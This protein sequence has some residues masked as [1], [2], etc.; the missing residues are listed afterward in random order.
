MNEKEFSDKLQLIEEKSFRFWFEQMKNAIQNGRM[1]DADISQVQMIRFF[2]GDQLQ[3]VLSQIEINQYYRNIIDFITEHEKDPYDDITYLKLSLCHLAIGDYIR[4]FKYLGIIEIKEDLPLE[5]YFALGVC[6]VRLNRFKTA[7][8]LFTKSQNSDDEIIKFDS[9][10]LKAFSLSKIER[11]N[12]SIILYQQLEDSLYSH[13]QISKEDIEFQI[14]HVLNQKNEIDLSCST[15]FSNSLT[16]A[17]SIYL[18]LEQ[19]NIDIVCVQRAYELILKGKYRDA[20]GELSNITTDCRS[21]FDRSLLM[22]YCFYDQRDFPNAS[23]CLFPLLSFDQIGWSIW[24]LVGLVLIRTGR[25]QSAI[26]A[27][28]N[29]RASN[30]LSTKILLNLAASYELEGRLNDAEKIYNDFPEADPL[31][32]YAKARLIYIR[33][34]SGKS[35][36][37]SVTPEI[38][39]IRIQDFFEP[40]SERAMKKFIDC[41]LFFSKET[42]DFLGCD[43]DF[44]EI[45]RNVTM[46]PNFEEFG[47]SEASEK[48]ENNPSI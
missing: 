46:F 5:Y 26:A 11:F 24:F 22:G 7:I 16:Q 35:Y 47:D 36:D 37:N 42:V 9:I 10:Y 19:K 8:D 12:E 2:R 14:A 15:Y 13:P 45:H 3:S 28:G 32:Q 4:A 41:P 31:N 48:S 25:I 27:F 43:P 44:S 40:P 17:N 18:N 20:F 39:E 6:N 30:L 33:S 29:A 38:F 34:R 21:K 1:K 23:R